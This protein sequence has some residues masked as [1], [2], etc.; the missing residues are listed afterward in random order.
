MEPVLGYYSIPIFNHRQRMG[1]LYS[2]KPTFWDWLKSCVCPCYIVYHN[3]LYIVK[4]E[5]TREAGEKMAEQYKSQPPMSQHLTVTPERVQEHVRGPIL[6]R[7]IRSPELSPQCPCPDQAPRSPEMLPSIPEREGSWPLISEGIADLVSGSPDSKLQGATTQKPAVAATKRISIGD[8]TEQ[9]APPGISSDHVPVREELP[10]DMSPP[11]SISPFKLHGLHLDPV[12]TATIAEPKV[13]RLSDH[14]ANYNIN[15]PTRLHALHLD[16]VV[17]AGSAQRPTQPPRKVLSMPKAA[18][19]LAPKIHRLSQDIDPSTA[20][21]AFP[22]GSP[23]PARVPALRVHELETDMSVNT[24]LSG[25]QGQQKLG[26]DLSEDV[27]VAA[28]A[29]GGRIGTP[30]TTLPAHELGGVLDEQT[31]P[32]GETETEVHRLSEDML[33]PSRI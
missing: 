18:Q 30:K 32:V 17:P 23:P 10:H 28:D 3:E 1:Q 29:S 5:A 13:H 11:S 15:Q 12:A 2:F 7:Q 20:P 16:L 24:A 26:H 19:P 21:G 31:V 33:M 14:V 22:P 25:R 27:K 8:S 9:E 4:A 6:G